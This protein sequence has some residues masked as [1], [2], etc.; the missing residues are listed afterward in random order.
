MI[1]VPG[2]ELREIISISE[3]FA[4]LVDKEMRATVER[5]VDNIGHVLVAQTMPE[6]ADT[7]DLNVM[8]EI[9]Q[10]RV[11][12]SLLPQLQ[13]IVLAG[14]ASQIRGGK[15]AMGEPVITG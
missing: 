11:T 1:E 9:W 12:E 15:T 5:S 3:L 2:T 10:E 14:M 7:D 13:A 8:L 4:S 6:A